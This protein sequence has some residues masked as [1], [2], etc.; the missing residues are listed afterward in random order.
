MMGHGAEI[1]WLESPCCAEF[2]KLLRRA[3]NSAFWSYFYHQTMCWCW[4]MWPTWE[5]EQGLMM[6]LSEQQH[7]ISR[8]KLTRGCFKFYMLTYSSV[9]SVLA[10][11]LKEALGISSVNS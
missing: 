8:V 7:I 9:I 5:H 10:V 2:A 4:D 6:L 3:P 1:S 11:F